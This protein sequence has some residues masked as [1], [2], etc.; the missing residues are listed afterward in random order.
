MD[1]VPSLDL[2]TGGDGVDVI[3]SLALSSSSNNMENSSD[4]TVT[5]EQR[6]ARMIQEELDAANSKRLTKRR[7]KN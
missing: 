1:S 2:N 4:N 3:S 6:K 5:I 7:R